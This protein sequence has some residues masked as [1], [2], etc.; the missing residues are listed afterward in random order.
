MQEVMLVVAKGANNS[1]PEYTLQ[2]G[3]DDGSGNGTA[4]ARVT[5]IGAAG[6]PLVPPGATNVGASSGNVANAV[7][8]AA[9]PAVAGKTNYVT[10]FSITG[11]GAT[12]A[13]VVDAT[14]TGVVGGPF[15]YT[16]AV[17]AGVAAGVLPLIV[18]LETPLAASAANQAV[19][20]SV[21]AFGAGNTNAAANIHGYV[22]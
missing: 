4:A 6:S 18:E 13:A 10:G 16:V 21:P 22:V 14:L 9:M 5:L 11:A 19:T 20:L 15:H 3:V 17:P 7:A 1:N 12:A 8:T 2:G